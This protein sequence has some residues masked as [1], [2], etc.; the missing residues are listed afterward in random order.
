MSKDPY[1]YDDTNVLKNL[2][3]L[4]NNISW[5]IMKLQWLI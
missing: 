2:E 3:I 5:M 4:K 1:V